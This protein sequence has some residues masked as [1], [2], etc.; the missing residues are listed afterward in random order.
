MNFVFYMFKDSLLT[1]S[2]THIFDNSSLIL[3]AIGTV[4]LLSTIR[5]KHTHGTNHCIVISIQDEIE[6]R[7]NFIDIVHI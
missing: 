7:A 6:L 5:G 1:L 4:S 3:T 2:Q